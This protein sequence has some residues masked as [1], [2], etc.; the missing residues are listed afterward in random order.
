MLKINGSQET[1]DLEAGL[2]SKLLG[3]SKNEAEAQVAHTANSSYLAFSD[4]LTENNDMVI[5]YPLS[6]NSYDY[7]E[8]ENIEYEKILIAKQG[9]VFMVNA[10]NPVEALTTQQVK[11]IYSGKIT[12]WKELGGND[13]VI[14][15]FQRPTNTDTQNCMIDF[16]GET[17]LAEPVKEAAEVTFGFMRYVVDNYDNSKSAIGYSIYTY[18]AENY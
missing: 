15:A 3:I 14:Q 13:A 1:I 8:T 2:K 18:G 9:L 5:S 10:D 12:N 4:M 11:D 6:Q 7:A 17:E 16:M